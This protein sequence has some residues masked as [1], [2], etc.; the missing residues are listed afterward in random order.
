LI[1]IIEIASNASSIFDK[2]AIMPRKPE[3]RTKMHYCDLHS[4]AQ[5]KIPLMKKEV[6]PKRKGLK[7][8]DL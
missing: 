5:N 4:L 2:K 6:T 8:K 3:P 7:T 1:T